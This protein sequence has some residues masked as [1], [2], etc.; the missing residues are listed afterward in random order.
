MRDSFFNQFSKEEGVW[1]VDVF[2][3]L[4]YWKASPNLKDWDSVFTKILGNE[5]LTFDLLIWCSVQNKDLKKGV[6]IVVVYCAVS[7]YSHY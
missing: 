6:D 1:K 2:Y 3:A 4:Q 5:N 7:K